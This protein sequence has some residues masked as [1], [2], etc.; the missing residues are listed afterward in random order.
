MKGSVNMQ[1]ESHEALLDNPYGTSDRAYSDKGF[2][3]SS[4]VAD[5]AIPV[6]IRNCGKWEL[7]L[8]N[9]ENGEQKTI[10]YT[11]KSWKCET[12]G[13]KK[14]SKLIA[15][16]SRASEAYFQKTFFT[17]T[18]PSE[19]HFGCS[20]K[21]GKKA[22]P[23]EIEAGRKY[24]VDAWS[25]LRKR[26]RRQ[27]RIVKYVWVL[28]N[29]KSGILHLHGML[30]GD[31]DSDWLKSAIVDCGLGKSL[32]VQDQNIKNAGAYIAKYIGKHPASIASGKR[33]YGSSQGLL[34]MNTHNPLYSGYVTNQ[35][36]TEVLGSRWQAL[37][38]QEA[39]KE[40]YNVRKP[41][42]DTLINFLCYLLINY[43]EY[44]LR[45]AKTAC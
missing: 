38:P 21:T 36:G 10:P 15:E 31:V 29:H 23:D 5:E 22:N 41:S 30:F 14:Q 16:I 37:H 18:L 28:E 42:K 11:C 19:L 39:V 44:A 3:N 8:I 4:H 2:S 9:K 27:N 33:R 1:V 34:S 35:A 40:L 6:Y 43:P 13:P 20:E 24:L 26:I 12:C 7:H 45:Y 32:D 25:K 17:I